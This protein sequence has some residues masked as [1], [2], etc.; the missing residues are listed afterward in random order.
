MGGRDL[1]QGPD[2]HRDLLLAEEEVTRQLC[3]LDLGNSALKL[4]HWELEG[5]CRLRLVGAATLAHADARFERELR[6]WI[7][8][9]KAQ[10]AALACVA[11]PGLE[12]RV[13][14]EFAAAGI[15][16]RRELAPGV[17]NLTRTPDTVGRDRLFAARGA[18]ELT[19][20]SCVVIDAGTA[21]TV[22]ALAAAPKPCFL[23]GAIAPGPALLARSLHEFTARLPLVDVDGA[24]SALGV[25]TPS[26]LRSGVLH[27]FRG[28]VLEL[29]RRIEHA[30]GGDVG[31]VVSGGAAQLLLEPTLFPGEVRHEPELVHLGLLAALLDEAA[32]ARRHGLRR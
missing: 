19:G 30:L 6:D 26:A 16:V 15:E 24:V 29:S 12:E 7:A 22:D 13:V 5:D 31:I 25:D 9:G 11:A 18:W 10:C 2:S 3:T 8:R 1:E 32:P 23:G 14:A 20:S 28:A 27:G 4:R 21:V 17:E